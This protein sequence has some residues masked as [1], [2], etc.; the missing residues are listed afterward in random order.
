MN[1]KRI[2]AS[3]VLTMCL[4]ILMCGCKKNKNDDGKDAK[5]PLVSGISKNNLDPNANP[6]D[7]F[8]QYAC[9]G[10]MKNNPLPPAYSRYGSFDQ[11][12]ESTEKQL[13]KLISE[14]AAQKNTSGTSSR[15]LAT[16]SMLVWTK[17][18][19][20]NWEQRPLS[21]CWTKFRR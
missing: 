17:R 14:V 16:F 9:G 1:H 12:G 4:C 15:K 11:L 19:S 3:I 10:W 5:K 2:S 8:Y 20:K 13:H 21:L 6:A 18:P 7:D